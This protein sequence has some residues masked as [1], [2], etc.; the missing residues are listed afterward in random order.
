[1]FR[2]IFSA[3]L[4]SGKLFWGMGLGVISST[5]NSQAVTQA[6]FQQLKLQQARQNAEKAE[7]IARALAEK[8][9][10]AQRE[11]VQADENARS[12]SAQS[13]QASNVAGQARQG[14]A[15]IRSAGDMQVRLANTVSQASERQQA[16]Q[17]SVQATRPVVNDAGQVTG[18]L[19]NVTA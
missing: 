9:A 18:T 10:V 6:A 12:L 8:A 13:D 1:M 3:I 16:V 17:P 15:L 11:A 19:V 2:R 5:A 14:L 7:Q 4:N